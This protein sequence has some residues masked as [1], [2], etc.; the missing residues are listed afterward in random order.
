MSN[1]NFDAADDIPINRKM[2]RTLGEV[3]Q[4]RL[5][6]RNFLKSTSSTAALTATGLALPLSL[7]ACAKGLPGFNFEEIAHGVDETHHVAPDHEADILIRWG[8]PVTAGAPTFDPDNQSAAAQAQQFGYNNDFVGFIPIP[9][10][11]ELHDR[12]LL[13]VNHEFTNDD[14]MHP[15]F[16]GVADPR[17]VYTKEIAEISMAAHGGSVIEIEKQDDGSWRPV[18]DS[19]FNRRIT[20]STTEMTL[21]GPAAGHPR[22]QTSRDPSGTKVI[23]TFNNC[24]GGITPWGTYLMAEENIHGYF[25]GT[26]DNHPERRNFE[27]L[28]IPSTFYPWGAFDDRFNINKEPHEANRFGWIVE[29]DPFDP[30][31]KPVKRTALGRFKHEGCETA[32]CPLGRVVIY[33]GD[34]Q[35]FEYLYRFVSDNVMSTDDRTANFGLL[36]SGTLS[37]AKLNDDGTGTWLPLRFGEGPLTSENGFES[38]ADVLIETRRA[39]DLMGATPLDRPEDVQPNVLTGKVY[40]SLTNNSKRTPE[41]TDAANPRG[42]NFWGQIV[43]LCP[44]AENHAAPN[45]TWDLLVVCGDPDDANVNARWNSATS[46]NGWFACPDN[47][48]VDPSGRLWAATDQGKE[49]SNTSGTAD[50]IWALDTDGEDR[51][52]STMF[53]RVPVGAEMCGPCFSNDGETLFVAV[54]HPASDGTDALPG[55]ERK[56][57]Y[58]DPA[59]R[60]P[61]FKPEMPPRPSVV[62]IRRKGGGTVG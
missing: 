4:A 46:E 59:T 11:T 54:Q 26:L 24:A 14:L 52:K 53:F 7:A 23:G 37:V 17:T 5:N 60:W 49:W 13:C 62:S 2:A 44:E 55:F 19:V 40:A 47:L 20:A 12:A 8:D 32:L 1:D 21:S 56:S 51:G 50:G 29:V 45:F 58:S 42:P 57:T 41:Q 18:A 15:I 9:F 22:L 34:D 10:G 28:G 25:L 31:S 35:R 30:T 36:D 43:E 38:Q 33:S 61:D 27:R 39:A 3:W 6:R 16:S 48:A